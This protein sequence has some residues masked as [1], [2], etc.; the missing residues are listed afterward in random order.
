MF[1][2]PLGTVLK[3]RGGFPVDASLPVS[4]IPPLHSRPTCVCLF[5][6]FFISPLLALLFSSVLFALRSVCACVCL[7]GTRACC[8]CHWRACSRSPPQGLDSGVLQGPGVK[9]VGS[10]RSAK[11]KLQYSFQGTRDFVHILELAK[12]NSN[13]KPVKHSNAGFSGEP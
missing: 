2:E 12:Q 13:K 8:S 4:A 3:A 11:P 10:A 6:G 1:A 5:L 7:C 9:P